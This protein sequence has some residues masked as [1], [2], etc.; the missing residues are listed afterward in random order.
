MITLD[1]ISMERLF[2][3][4]YEPKVYKTLSQLGAKTVQDVVN[5]AGNFFDETQLSRINKA[6]DKMQGQIQNLN[7]NERELNIY[8]VNRDNISNYTD[9]S[10]P[11][12]VLILKNPTLSHTSMYGSLKEK[13]ID[14]IKNDLQLMTEWG[15]NYLIFAYRNIGKENINKILEALNLYDEQVQRQAKL[16]DEDELNK[17]FYSTQ[18]NI[19]E[20]DYNE[21]ACIASENYENIINYFVDNNKDLI[22]G[23][24][25]DNQKRLYVASMN[26]K[27]ESQRRI[28]REI[29]TYIAN[30]TLLSELENLEK[31]DYKLLTKFMK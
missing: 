25:S 14:Q 28:R 16:I 21:K 31:D 2:M 22:W 4:V 1:N 11:G 6:I 5:N 29:I 23:N 20:H 26:R 13:S 7:K 18:V 24:M 27:T 19:F 10:N 8:N 12:S 3:R 15:D 17:P 9:R 30:Y